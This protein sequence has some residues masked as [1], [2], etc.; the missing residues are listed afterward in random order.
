M[1]ECGHRW[2]SQQAHPSEEQLFRAFDADLT[3]IE[4]DNIRA[5]V[6]KCWECRAKWDVWSNARSDYMLYKHEV[7]HNVATP[8]AN[9]A[10]FQLRLM[11]LAEELDAKKEQRRA[12]ALVKFFQTLTAVPYLRASIAGVI[13]IL[14]V[15]VSW[16]VVGHRKAP[17]ANASE[18]LQRAAANEHAELL[19]R[20]HPVAY[21]KLHIKVNG[22]GFARTIY[23]DMNSSRQVDQIDSDVKAPSSKDALE[24]LVRVKGVFSAAQL[25]WMAPLSPS[26]FNDWRTAS[27][28][29]RERILRS[30]EVTEVRT[31]VSDGPITEASMTLRNSDFHPVAEAL[32]LNDGRTVEIAEMD[33]NIFEFSQLSASL[34]GTAEPALLTAVKPAP[35]RLASLSVDDL[36]L[37]ALIKLDRVDALVKDQVKVNTVDDGKILI[38][39]VVDTD[40][41]KAEL[42]HALAAIS[43]AHS[44]RIEIRTVAEAERQQS[45]DGP[46]KLDSIDV[47]RHLTP[48]QEYLRQYLSA[49]GFKGDQLETELQRGTYEIFDHSNAALVNAVLLR[50]LDATFSQS[51]VGRMT[52]DA[53]AKWRSLRER[54][55]EAVVRELAELRASLQPF[56]PTSERSAPPQFSV[57]DRQNAA[58]E[59]SELVAEV[60]SSLGRSL[61]ISQSGRNDSVQSPKF[62]E[63]IS[64]TEV[65]ASAIAD[66]AA[67]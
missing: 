55:A 36:E 42:Q 67:N 26:R 28:V 49:R 7:Q 33:Y 25:D 53:H 43:M 38:H 40:E 46:L 1:T 18:V 24:E 45:V 12:R 51:Q 59:L 34:F 17:T 23:R 29:R 52:A 62:W 9:W 32:T 66:E 44:V 61:A 14:L 27:R 21:Q 10:P 4:A 16:D 37:E 50:Q 19:R 30:H 2:S 3:Q 35:D 20:V 64:R 5:H 6:D 54:H 56:H 41:R 22:R 65:L 8:P 13:A 57:R 31:E 11:R 63:L 39:G 60:D 47:S 58:A 48:D 15:V